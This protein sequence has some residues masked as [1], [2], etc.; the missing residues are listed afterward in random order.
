[1]KDFC[2][3]FKRTKCRAEKSPMNQSGRG[4]SLVEV[5]MVMGAT[6]L[7][8]LAMMRMMQVQSR[9]TVYYEERNEEIQVL[10]RLNQFLRDG[11]RCQSTMAQIFMTETLPGSSSSPVQ[12][13]SFRDQNGRV[14]PLNRDLVTDSKTERPLTQDRIESIE[15]H[16]PF[17]VGI[18]PSGGFQIDRGEI[19]LDIFFA[20]N[21]QSLGPSQG[22]RKPLFLD[23]ITTDTGRI[24]KCF[25]DEDAA[26][27]SAYEMI[28]DDMGG[29][30]T[31]NPKDSTQMGEC[32]YA[33]DLFRGQHSTRQCELS[34]GVPIL[35]SVDGQPQ[36]FCQV[37]MNSSGD[38]PEPFRSWNTYENWSAAADFTSPVDACHPKYQNVNAANI[39]TIDP[40]VLYLPSP[41]SC[42]ATGHGWS[43]SSRNSCKLTCVPHKKNPSDPVP[44]NPTFKVDFESRFVARAMY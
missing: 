32:K 12:V 1:M 17:D 3:F 35:I 34:G 29:E 19:R 6:S 39:G 18:N 2:L 37:S 15:I 11:E 4:F 21:E 8:A 7:V 40:D 31:V 14:Y 38:I 41:S 9:S 13:T 44:K 25:S 26:I 27:K 43:N 24:D 5:L 33:F 30:Y 22:I 10:N 16:N 36:S 23:V 28:C 20:R 42:T